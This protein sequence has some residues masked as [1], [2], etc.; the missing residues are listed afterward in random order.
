MALHTVV[1]YPLLSWVLAEALEKLLLKDP[2]SGRKQ[3]GI[4][5]MAECGKIEP[6]CCTPAPSLRFHFSVTEEAQAPMPGECGLV[7]SAG[8][9]HV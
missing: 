6:S 4:R 7:V 5:K 1:N 3:G 2:E 8:L 9:D